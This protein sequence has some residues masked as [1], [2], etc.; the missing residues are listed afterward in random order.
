QS[1]P[2][3][4]PLSLHDA[5]PISLSTVLA[6]L[7]KPVGELTVVVDI[8]QTTDISRLEGI[9][10]AEIVALFGQ[11]TFNDC[12]TKRATIARFA[13]SH[14]RS[15]EHTSELQSLRHLVCR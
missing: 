4:Y 9:S 13:K 15:E 3:V 14:G 11:M 10:D 5:L 2:P 8:G 6:R 7:E 1:P 12:G